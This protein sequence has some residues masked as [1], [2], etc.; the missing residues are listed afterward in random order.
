MFDVLLLNRYVAYRFF[1]NRNKY[2]DIELPSLICTEFPFS[3]LALHYPP[4]Q[5]LTRIHNTRERARG[6]RSFSVFFFFLFPLSTLQ[7]AA[8]LARLS[9]LLV[10]HTRACIYS[11]ARLVSHSRNRTNSL[12]QL[13]S[14]TSVFFPFF[15]FST[16]T[17]AWNHTCPVRPSRSSRPSRIKCY[18]ST[19]NNLLSLRRDEQTSAMS[20]DRAS[21]RELEEGDRRIRF[22]AE[23]VS[24]DS[25]TSHPFLLEVKLFAV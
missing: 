15:F 22:V 18:I 3:L 17:I 9:F 16:T 11:Y 2:I 24:R 6:L 21:D 12:I 4:T 7:L 20:D 14:R 23:P 19:I 25:R 5:L 10:P 8:P 1:F 13:V